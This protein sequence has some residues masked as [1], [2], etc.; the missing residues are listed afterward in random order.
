MRPNF[1]AKPLQNVKIGWDGDLGHELG[2]RAFAHRR[3]FFAAFTLV[4][5]LV[6]IAIIGVLI[7]LLLPA[8]QSA[9][10]AARRMQCQNH[11][12]QLGLAVHNFHDTQSALP[13]LS[14]I[15]VDNAGNEARRTPNAWFHLFPYFEKQSLY[16]YAA[17]RAP[18]LVTSGTGVISYNHSWWNSDSTSAT[19]PM[20]DSIRRGFAG[21]SVMACPSRRA[22]GDF[23]PK[24][25]STHDYA[26]PG[27]RGDYVFPHVH[28]HDGQGTN[29]QMWWKFF[30]MDPANAA[31]GNKSFHKGPLTRAD[32]AWS[33]NAFTW[34]LSD[35]MNRWQDGSS[36][37]FLIGE[38]HVPLGS[39]QVCRYS[40]SGNAWE[41]MDCSYLLAS[42]GVNSLG[43]LRPMAV[44]NGNS[45]TYETSDVWGI[46]RSNDEIADADH[47]YRR[48]PA[49][50]FGS[51]HPGVCQFVL[52]DGSVRGVPTTT[53]NPILYRLSCI[54]D[55]VSVTLP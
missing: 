26:T 33:N 46:W 40:G 9:R 38:K 5:L 47:L 14:V 2:S 35:S 23:V 15:G 39:F 34:T 6:V 20:N 16:D 55:G 51:W 42:D 13:P 3:R 30:R 53:A 21:V 19:A 36:N 8:V 4:E 54:D 25:A 52:G 24:D 50:S 22:A 37:Q 10:E 17:T 41:A 1:A 32:G 11:I 31:G 18:N 27:P 28:V 12:K 45:T 44:H 43:V 48:T 29:P 49:V 7:A